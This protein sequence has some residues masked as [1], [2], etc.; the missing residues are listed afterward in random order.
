MQIQFILSR[1][2]ICHPTARLASRPGRTRGTRRMKALALFLLVGACTAAPPEPPDAASDAAPP[3]SDPATSAAVAPLDPGADLSGVPDSLHSCIPEAFRELEVRFEYVGTI[4]PD[5][6][7]KKVLLEY[8]DDGDPA[9]PL[10]FYPVIL[11]VTASSCFSEDAPDAATD[12]GYDEAYLLLT[13]P[14]LAERHAELRVDA[15]GGPEAFARLYRDTV[16]RDMRECASDGDAEFD[17]CVTR[18]EARSYRSLGVP[19]DAPSPR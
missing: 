2:L 17:G 6:S 11:N 18:L 13:S 4:E 10:A 3:A 15:A 12:A 14:E 9:A 7:P 5:G 19:V 16:G 8:F 1:P